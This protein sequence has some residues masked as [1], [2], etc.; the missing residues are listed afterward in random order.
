[1]GDG[2]CS[3][4]GDLP[5]IYLFASPGQG[6]LVAKTVRSARA[7]ISDIRPRHGVGWNDFPGSLVSISKSAI[8]M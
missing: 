8:E 3:K 7:D 4:A 2:E 6:H 5:G 1:M